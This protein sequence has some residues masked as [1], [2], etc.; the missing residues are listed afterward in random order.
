MAEM[1]KAHT[2][3][4]IYCGKDGVVEVPLDE[5]TAWVGGKFIQDAMPSLSA[6]QREQILTGT[7]AE[8]WDKMFPKE[9]D[10]V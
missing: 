4:C 7:H 6:E 2:G 3:S 9:D 8:C 1:F 10:W 5:F